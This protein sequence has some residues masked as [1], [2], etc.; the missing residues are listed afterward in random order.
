MSD[1]DPTNVPPEFLK[2]GADWLAVF[3][4]KVPRVM[5][6]SLAAKYPHQTVVCSVRFS[7]D[8]TRVAVGLDDSVQ[9]HDIA[10]DALRIL[11][12]VHE[13]SRPARNPVRGVAFSPDGRM[14]AAASDDGLIRIWDVQTSQLAHTLSGHNRAIYAIEFAAS[15]HT[16]LSASLDR[17][18]RV[19]DLSA[20]SPTASI[21][22]VPTD[23]TIPS[24]G[25]SALAVSPDGRR[26]AT[27]LVNGTLRVWD[28]PGAR[29]EAEWCG[30][31]ESV[32]SV[33]FVLQG[34]GLIS[35]SLDMTLKRW[36][37]AG[38]EPACVKTMEG[39]K[40][41][42]LAA[43]TVQEGQMLRAASGSRDRVVRLWDAKT[44]ETLFLIHGHRNSV[45]AVDLSSDGKMLVSGSG[46]GE[47]R[48]CERNT[49][50]FLSNCCHREKLTRIAGRYTVI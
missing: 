32:Y 10:T 26:A 43:A 5:D 47:A 24:T 36:A 16:L 3:S 35:A 33:R 30:H 18:L 34:A 2:E 28:I 44:G 7:P 41:F 40:D 13:G 14:L 22:S 15:G 49:H 46:D 45:T 23:L 25:L 19:W 50:V 20:P 21:L 29:V 39:H 38:G 1:L 27:G 17:T 42:V 12:L 31:E 6:V 37:L 48:I 4:P 9:V 8:A 11:P